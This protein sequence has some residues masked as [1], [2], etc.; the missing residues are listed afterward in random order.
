MIRFAALLC[1]L[2][3]A[4]AATAQPAAPVEKDIRVFGQKIHYLESGSTGPVVILLHGLGASSAHWRFTIPALTGQHVFAPDQLGF[5]KSD[6]PEI[7]YRI[8][9]LVDTLNE[10]YAQTGITRATLVGSSMGGWVA[11]AFASAY[12]DKVERLILVDSSGYTQQRWGGPPVGRQEMLR[13]NPSTLADM[14][15]LLL[16]LFANKALVTDAAVKAA[17]EQ[18]LAAGDGNVINAFV[19]SIV[20]NE[21]YLDGKLSGLTMPTLLIWGKEDALVPLA[22]ANAFN[23]DIKGSK[24]TVLN[25]CGH[26]PQLE[27]FVPFN[28]ALAGFLSGK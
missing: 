2:S 14:R 6:K 11:A 26:V 3:S 22:V 25:G 4:S 23:A 8:S 1:V 10:F 16:T 13:L 19:E 9:T 20:R 21:D 27:C 7:N 12:P 28:A 17:F 18:K 24:L 15:A 5:G